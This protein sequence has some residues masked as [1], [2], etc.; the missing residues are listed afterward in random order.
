M[1]ERSE[2]LLV[3]WGSRAGDLRADATARRVL[4]I[5]VEHPVVAPDLVAARVDDPSAPRG[6]PSPSWPTGASSSPMKVRRLVRAGFVGPGWH[7][8]SSVWLRV[9]V[10]SDR[11]TQVMTSATR[12]PSPP[13]GGS[14]TDLSIATKWL[15]RGCEPVVDPQD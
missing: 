2:Q 11:K 3:E 13:P 4:S 1:A 5:L 12:S 10:P 9:G 15:C 14:T 8:T 6:Q 7:P